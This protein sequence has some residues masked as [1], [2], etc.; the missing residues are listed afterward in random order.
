MNQ[1][2]VLKWMIIFILFVFL[3]STWLVSVMYFVDKWAMT[4]TWTWE[5][6]TG[7]LNNT[8]T[9]LSWSN[10]TGENL[11]GKIVK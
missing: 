4:G 10:I 11:T 8:W 9:I 1:K 5:N 3:L 2:R 6:L 7:S